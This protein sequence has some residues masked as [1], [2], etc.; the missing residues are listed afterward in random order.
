MIALIEIS[1]SR[2]LSWFSDIGTKLHSN[3]YGT[4]RSMSK[5][6]QPTLKYLP[7]YHS[8]HSFVKNQEAC[9]NINKHV[10]IMY[11]LF[12]YVYVCQ[13]QFITFSPC[14]QVFV[15][16][17]VCMYIDGNIHIPHTQT[18]KKKGATLRAY[19][20]TGK[21]NSLL[22]RY[23]SVQEQ[24]WHSFPHK[25]PTENSTLPR[26]HKHIAQIFNSQLIL[27][28]PAKKKSPSMQTHTCVQL[29]LYLYCYYCGEQLS[30]MN[31]LEGRW[32]WLLL[33]LQYEEM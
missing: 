7:T 24:M 27:R 14:K 25:I 15:Y 4:C 29:L 19:C 30:A 22:K 23:F 20:H 16:N 5:I 32:R 3:L 10:L 12:R 21:T 31:I 17:A 18:T 28:G 8:K 2:N 26:P 1:N 6:L 13:I 11:L 33:L 9:N